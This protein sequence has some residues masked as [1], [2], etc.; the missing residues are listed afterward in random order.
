MNAPPTAPPPAASANAA[1]LVRL[2]ISRVR[3]EHF[4]V[5]PY[6]YSNLADAL[7]EARRAGVP[8]KGR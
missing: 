3:T 1:E 2:G 6:R 4:E 5:G 8:G 7:A